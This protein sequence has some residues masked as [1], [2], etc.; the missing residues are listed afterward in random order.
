MVSSTH[1]TATKINSQDKRGL[2]AVSC[3]QSG[4]RHKRSHISHAYL[5]RTPSHI[6]LLVLPVIISPLPRPVTI[7]A[8]AARPRAAALRLRGRAMTRVVEMRLSPA[9]AHKAHDPRQSSERA[10][11]AQQP[12]RL[13]VGRPRQRVVLALLR[14]LAGRGLA[15]KRP[16]QQRDGSEQREGCV[17][18]PGV[19]AARRIR[20][21]RRRGQ[22]AQASALGPRDGG[23]VGRGRQ[24]TQGTK[25][26]A[27]GR[28]R[29]RGGGCGSGG[30]FVG[31]AFE[32][33]LLQ[34]GVDQTATL[35]IG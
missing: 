23:R 13:R 8:A 24:R 9:A 4:D 16:A 28:V 17:G 21:R 3:R 5:T 32:A 12:A 33:E 34:N 35:Y 31:G 19:E 20:A 22:P 14:A 30:V 10:E 26:R 29:V 11:R 15:R 18:A 7:A 27:C 1:I 6:L 25:A 2:Q